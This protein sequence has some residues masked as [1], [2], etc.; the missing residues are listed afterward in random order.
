MDY[1]SATTVSVFS[2]SNTSE[3]KNQTEPTEQLPLEQLLE[4]VR[5]ICREYLTIIFALFGTITNLINVVILTEKNMRSSTNY[6]LTVLAILDM[7]FLNAGVINSFSLFFK[8]YC[9]SLIG[10]QVHIYSR[11]FISTA[12]NNAVTIICAFTVERYF[13]GMKISNL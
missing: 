7:L 9:S 10:S 13:A 1:N 12:S 5:V 11:L 8:Q 3:I 4:I 2:F 6:Y